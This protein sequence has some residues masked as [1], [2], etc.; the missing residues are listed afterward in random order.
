MV[1][2]GGGEYIES[3]ALDGAGS[4]LLIATEICHLAAVMSAGLRPT[5]S[6][7]HTAA[8]QHKA[9]RGAV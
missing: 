9:H 5:N 6:D 3:V 7:C 2:L 1:S 8:R 4:P